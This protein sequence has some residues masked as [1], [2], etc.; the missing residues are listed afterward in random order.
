MKNAPFV[1][2]ALLAAPLALLPAATDAQTGNSAPGLSVQP[3]IVPLPAD[4]PYPG[5]M[6]LKVDA[7]DV[8]RGIFHDRQTIPVAK[9][10][11]LTLLY[12][13]WLPGKHAPRGAIADLAG[14]KALGR[15]SCRERRCQY[16]LKSGGA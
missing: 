2:A 15:A 1:A 13:E 8:A 5:T 3:H 6:V 12:P 4:K 9:G 14:F 10:G 7:T 11:K 16:V